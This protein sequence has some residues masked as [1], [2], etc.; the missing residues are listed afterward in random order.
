[1]KKL[2]PYLPAIGDFV[3]Q[4]ETKVRFVIAGALNT[5]LGIALFPILYLVLSPTGLHYL[6]ILAFSGVVC[7]GFAFLT[8]KFLVFRTS[9]NYLKEL[10]RFVAFHLGHFALSLI[11]VPAVVEFGGISPIVAQPFFVVAIVVS[12][13][14]WH[15]YVT[16]ESD[17]RAKAYVLPRHRSYEP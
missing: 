3:R 11:A 16:F 12:S 14:F 6:I 15:R 5:A 2:V 17:G 8:N 7:I 1:M 9:G 13:Y 10:S 4:H